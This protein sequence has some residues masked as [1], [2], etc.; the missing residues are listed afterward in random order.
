[1]QPPPAQREAVA[2]GKGAVVPHAVPAGGL[3]LHHKAGREF[4]LGR[5]RDIEYTK[6][7]EKGCGKVAQP[8]Q[9]AQLLQSELF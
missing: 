1:M 6:I 9:K 5:L 7:T 4:V 3:G 2:E 8:F